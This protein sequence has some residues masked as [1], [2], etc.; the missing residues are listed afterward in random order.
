MKVSFT[1]SSQVKSDGV[2]VFV[3]KDRELSLTAKDLDKKSGGVITTAMTSSKFSGKKGEVLFITPSSSLK[4][5]RI[6]LVGIGEASKFGE[7]AAQEVGAA[8]A[9]AFE[10]SGQ[11]EVT[12]FVDEMKGFPTKVAELAA[13]VAYGAKLRSYR[14]DKYFTKQEAE[15]RPTLKAVQISVKNANAAEKEYE[16]FD[17]IADAVYWVRDMISEPANVLYPEVMAN[18]AKKLSKLGVKVEILDENQMRKL[19]MG[20]LLGVAQGSVHKPRLVVMQ[21]NGNPKA[22]AKDKQPLAFVG[23][24]VT[25]DSG[26]I[27]IK[28]SAKMEEMKSDMAGA[29]AVM[30]L[31]YALA[32]RKAKVNVVGIAGIVENMPSGS[33]QRPGDVVKSMS[34]QTI[35]VINTDAEGRLVLA[36]AVWYAHKKFNP[37]LMVDLATLTGAIRIALGLEYAGLFASDDK[38]AD[39][40]VAS[41]DST[42]EKLWR[43]PMCDA[44]DKEVNSEIADMKNSTTTD[45]YAGS[46]TAAHFIKRFAGN[47][48]WA[49]L[50]IAGRDW[51]YQ[52]KG[53]N[54]KGAIGFG[55]RLLERFIADN[56]E[57]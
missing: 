24:G 43:M 8:V 32:K 12:I 6:L 13:N 2:A 39:K 49:H 33:A 15:R 3:A 25:F 1:N 22:K 55:V 42:G 50:D 54:P 26:G 38:L 53:T 4:T 56:Y 57:K 7:L 45:R 37:L 20:A 48:P 52:G 16:R 19:G 35:E 21:Y 23:K 27:S 10:K 51:E 11:P 30:G 18:E 28:P 34:G 41:G 5:K 36:D 14:F 46:S 9:V 40:L 44:F 31:M 29:A 17:A 47:T